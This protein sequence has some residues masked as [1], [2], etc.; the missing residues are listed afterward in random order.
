MQRFHWFTLAAG[1]TVPLFCGGCASVTVEDGQAHPTPQ[2]VDRRS[3]GMA[4][5]AQFV[6][7]PFSVRPGGAKEN[8]ARKHPGQLAN[9]SQQLLTGFLVEEL[10][11]LGLPASAGVPIASGRGSGSV[12]IVSGEITRVAEGNRL[13][14]MGIGLGAGGTKM[15]TQVSVQSGGANIL[16][17]RTTGGSNAMPGAATTPIP[18]SS[19]PAWRHRR[20]RAHG[21]DDRCPHRRR[22]RAARM[23]HRPAAG[24]ENGARALS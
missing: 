10:K 19:L 21:P 2:H 1:I 8:P 6:V 24:A 11:K 15:E 4:R 20:C 7:T 18:F 9:E 5:P 17:F 16:N 3:G 23:V 13:L 22:P 14:R 12:W